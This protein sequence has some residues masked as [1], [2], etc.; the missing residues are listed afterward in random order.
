MNYLFEWLPLAAI[1]EDRIL[2]LHGGIGS[3]V[4][5]IDDIM[6]IKRPIDI[7]H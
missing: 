3:S 1:V 7:S 5:S 6:R 4:Q 2:C